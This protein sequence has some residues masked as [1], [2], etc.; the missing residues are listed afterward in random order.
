MAL[1][2]I[3]LFT[4]GGI[5]DETF[6]RTE[7]LLGPQAMERLAAAHVAVFGPDGG[8]M[9]ILSPGKNSRTDIL[10]GEVLDDYEKFLKSPDYNFWYFLTID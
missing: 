5:M 4:P 8:L 1:S 2:T 7:M 6:L 3:R 9:L 10:S